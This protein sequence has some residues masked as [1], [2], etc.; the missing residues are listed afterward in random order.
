M[1]KKSFPNVMYVNH[2]KDQGF[3]LAEDKLIHEA[4]DDGELVA[5]YEL[6][7]VK[8]VS[9]SVTLLDPKVKK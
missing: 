4:L 2:D 7:E 6:K 9:K 5:I 3:Y 8:K 1:P